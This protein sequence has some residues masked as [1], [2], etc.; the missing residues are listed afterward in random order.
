MLPDHEPSAVRIRADDDGLTIRHEGVIGRHAVMLGLI[1]VGL[2]D[3]QADRPPAWEP[4]LRARAAEHIERMEHNRRLRA[5][6]EAKTWGGTPPAERLR[7][8]S[9]HARA[10]ARRSGC[11]RSCVGH[12]QAGGLPRSDG[13]IVARRSSM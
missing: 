9:G 5:Q 6:K 7:V 11:R 2:L 10:L 8:L 12:R 13:A 1:W 3:K 4:V